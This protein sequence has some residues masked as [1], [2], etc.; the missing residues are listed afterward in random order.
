M[1]S[2]VR[3]WPSD[4]GN[5]EASPVASRGRR[6]LVVMI[7]GVPLLAGAAMAFWDLMAGS[8]DAVTG[9]AMLVIVA[10]GTVR[11]QLTFWEN[12]ALTREL[13]SR[14][15][16]RTEQLATL[17]YTDP[18]TGLANRARFAERLADAAK[19]G[20]PPVLLL[21]DLDGFK[22]INDT[23]GHAAGD[24]LLQLV[25]QRLR[26]ACSGAEVL[27]RLG[28][29][30]FAVVLPRCA[31][32]E[33]TRVADQVLADLAEPFRVGRADV[34]LGGSIGI[35]GV[36]A[37]PSRGDQAGQEDP[38]PEGAL[39]ARDPDVLRHADLAMYAA[40]AAGR[41]RWSV[42]DPAMA[43]VAA[44]R[45]ELE[46]DLRLALPRGE[47]HLVYQ[48][49]VELGT[50]RTI[51]LE[52]LL[53]WDHP[54]YGE[55][56]PDE[57]IPVAE[58]SGLIVPIGA[59]VLQEAC[60]Q[61]A[62]WRAQQRQPDLICGLNLSVHQLRPDFVSLVETT[63]RETGLP[64]T[65]LVLEVTESVF[66]DDDRTDPEVL[67][68]LR[69]LGPRIFLDDFG[70]GY[71]SLGYLRRFPVDGLKIDRSFVAGLGPD[72]GDA[73]CSAILRIAESLDLSVVAEGIEQP[74]QCS[75]LLELGCQLGQGHSLARPV[76]PAVIDAV[77]GARRTD[78]LAA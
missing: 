7:R 63:L 72:G 57:F 2:V 70:T 40:K 25:A 39:E 27:A 54:I 52:A 38:A 44:W 12:D 42:F 28:G 4:G 43:R 49:V 24:E 67:Q 17:A 3:R 34:R 48:P 19:A 46:E 77:L 15:E 41:N 65:S 31:A 55:M 58:E 14:V 66:M 20:H 74:G 69:R 71:S 59:W 21:L 1:A 32:E 60:R 53:R 47:L 23:L 68:Q 29:D 61:V 78:S 22:A 56:A 16:Q 13:E 10:L 5:A 50:G 64:A 35:A 8:L 18:L 11:Q 62:R 26:R 73:I 37:I 36:R 76:D 75:A 30:E 51:G 33:A 45:R 6:A 9:S